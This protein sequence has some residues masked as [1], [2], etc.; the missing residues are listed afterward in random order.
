MKKTLVALADVSFQL[1][2]I[3]IDEF[4]ERLDVA[5][6]LADDNIGIADPRLPESIE[7]EVKRETTASEIS[8]ISIIKQSPDSTDWIEFLFEN[9]WYFTKSD[10][11]PFPST[12]H[13]HLDNPN[14]VWPKLSPYTGRVFK[15]KNQEDTSMRLSK[16]QMK[17]LWN[18]QKFRSFCREHI[19]WFM[20]EYPHHVFPVGN[21]LR[22]PHW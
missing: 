13:G 19:V 20:E 3:G 7:D 16:P 12:P 22:F 17:K 5:H 9:K 21:P 4:H 1:G 8:L 6:W 15:A 11:D 10:P 14:Q 2:L 18:D